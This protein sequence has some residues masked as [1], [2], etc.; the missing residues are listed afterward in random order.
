MLEYRPNWIFGFGF[1]RVLPFLF[2]LMI[3]SVSLFSKFVQWSVHPA[4]SV[5]SSCWTVLLATPWVHPTSQPQHGTAVLSPKPHCIHTAPPFS[6]TPHSPPPSTFLKMDTPLQPER[7]GRVPGSRRS[8]RWNV[9]VL[10]EDWAAATAVVAFWILLQ[11]LGA[12]THRCRPTLTLTCWVLTAHTWPVLRSTA[13][14][15]CT[16]AQAPGL[17]PRILPNYGTRWGRPLQ[18]SSHPKVNML[19]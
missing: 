1:W 16:P 7:A 19:S 15:R 6:I 17:A 3:L 10:W 12:Y 4:S 5:T 14:L 2:K 9:L 18:V 13:L 11:L 8:W